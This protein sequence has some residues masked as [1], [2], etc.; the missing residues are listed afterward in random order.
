MFDKKKPNLV[1]FLQF[2]VF[3]SYPLDV[4]VY[5]ESYL[6]FAKTASETFNIFIV[7]GRKKY[8]GSGVFSNGY[9]F[10]YNKYK[11]YLDPIKADVIFDKGQLNVKNGKTWQVINQVG[12]NRI[13][14]NKYQTYLLFKRFS[15]RTCQFSDGDGFK[16]CLSR[17]KTELV[18]YKPLTGFG[19]KGVKIGTKSQIAAETRKFS[20]AI[21]Q[22]FIDTSAGISGL[23]A[24]YHDFRVTIMNGKIVDTYL[25]LPQPGKLISNLARGG[26]FKAVALDKT[27]K[28]VLRIVKSVDNYFKRFGSRIYAIDFGFENNKPYIIEINSEPGMPIKKLEKDYKYIHRQIYLVTR[29]ALK[30]NL[31]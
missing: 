1:I 14:K 5:Y 10:S 23:C 16:R 26:I 20:N 22:E 11:K 17:L 7:R 12:L 25:R 2:G 9:I 4:P 29:S 8:L 27:P 19:G 30:F 21:L 15:K 3:Y 31:K 6:D 24:G 28:S 18:V 13:C